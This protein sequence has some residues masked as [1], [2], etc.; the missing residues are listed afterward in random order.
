[1]RIS[2]NPLRSQQFPA[3]LLLV[4]AGLG[5]LL[6]NLPTH[7]ALAAVLDFHIAVPGTSLDLSIEHWV[8]DGLLAVFFLVVAIELRHELTHGELDSPRKAVQPAIAAAGGV[9]VPIAVYLLIAGDSAT[10]T[11]WPIPTATDIAFALGVLA[12]FGRGL[13]PTVRVFLLA[14]AILD[15]IIGIIFIAVLFAHDVQ[16]LLLALAVVAVAVFWLLSKLLHAKGHAAIAVAMVV[17]G[18]LAWGLVAA[19]GIHA[20]IAGVMLGL[21]MSPVPAARTRHALEPTVNGVILPVF[22]FVAAFVVIPDLA[23]SELSPAFWGIVVALPVGKILGISLFGW[24]AMRIRPRGAAPAL[25]FGDILAAGALGGIGFTVSLLL[26]N[27]AFASD[28]GIRDQAILGVLVGS[29][30]ALVL[31]AVIVS[32][33]ARSYRRLNAATS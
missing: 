10:A 6:A 1:M 28:A 33:R 14:L 7:D 18:L 29:L 20:T 25:P 9:L 23:L 19:S 21:V 15:D 26:A 5:L 24:L 8:S 17:V 12:V 27:L 2:A 3:V 31:S 30:L 11:G 13:P 22:A 32:L 16:W 4:A